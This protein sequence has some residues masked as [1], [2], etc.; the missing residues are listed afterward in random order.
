MKRWRIIAFLVIMT[1]MLSCFDAD[2]IDP[3]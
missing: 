1:S 2:L 3:D